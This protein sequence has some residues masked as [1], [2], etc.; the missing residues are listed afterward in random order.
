MFQWSPSLYRDIPIL[1]Q[2]N[3]LADN[4]V[5]RTAGVD[6]TAH[7]R[8]HRPGVSESTEAG[9]SAVTGVHSVQRDLRY[10][11]GNPAVSDDSRGQTV[12]EHR[13]PDRP[14]GDTNLAV[15]V[16]SSVYRPLAVVS[17]SFEA[18]PPASRSEGFRLVGSTTRVGRG[19]S[20]HDGGT[21]NGLLPSD[22][23]FDTLFLRPPYQYPVI[24]SHKS[25]GITGRSTPAPGWWGRRP[26]KSF[27]MGEQRPSSPATTE[28]DSHIKAP[29]STSEVARLSEV[30]WGRL[31]E[32]RNFSV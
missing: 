26:R 22:S 28:G 14:G 30:G 3:G 18:E 16:G 8:N 19:G 20:R 13:R 15:S 29:P 1:S 7:S 31:R 10:R 25:A 23:L 21:D 17:A 24:P 12:L 27:R 4:A 2:L 11:R 5:Y 9:C 32:H 6:R